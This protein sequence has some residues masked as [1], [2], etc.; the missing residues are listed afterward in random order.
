MQVWHTHDGPVVSV[1]FAPDGQRLATAG[2]DAIRVWAVGDDQPTTVI[3]YQCFRQVAFTP[4]GRR[5]IADGEAGDP[6]FAWDVDTGQRSVLAEP[7]GISWVFAYDSA[8]RLA[9]YSNIEF[10]SNDLQWYSFPNA[11]W[12]EEWSDLNPSGGYVLRF[13]PDGRHLALPSNEQL[14]VWDLLTRKLITTLPLPEGKNILLEYSPDGGQL[15][16]GTGR[17]L[18]VLEAGRLKPVHMLTGH[19]HN[20][21]AV[22]FHPSG[23]YLAATSN[24][25]TVKL[26]DTESWAVAKT[27]SWN[28]GKLRSV[29]FSPDGTLVAAGSDTGRIVVWDV[30][31]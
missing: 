7:N 25:A 19:R 18:I 3:D 13:S 2:R 16:Y 1:V 23:R 27:Y 26:Y 9:V 24:D 11:A 10:L 28:V 22:A 20:I 6:V 15:M 31:L 21:T 4:D 12:V 8:G 17:R 30:D 29:A 14:T 5:V